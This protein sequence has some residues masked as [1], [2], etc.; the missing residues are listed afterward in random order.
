MTDELTGCWLN[1]WL[2]YWL[3]DCF[4]YWLM[5]CLFTGWWTSGLI[6][7]FADWLIDLLPDCVI[8]WLIDWLI[9]IHH[10]FNEYDYLLF[11]INLS[12]CLFVH[13]GRWGWQWQWQLGIPHANFPEGICSSCW[14]HSQVLVAL[15]CICS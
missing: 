8:D 4:S 1:D 2:V 13:S 5:D 6:I 10:H 7:W 11:I 9:I 3:T 12:F 15:H 14:I